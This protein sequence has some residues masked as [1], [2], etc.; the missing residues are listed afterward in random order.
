MVFFSHGCFSCLN[1]K[2]HKWPLGLPV[3]AEHWVQGMAPWTAVCRLTG[4]KGSVLKAQGVIHVPS[5]S[6]A[7]LSDT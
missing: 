5:H 2:R 7:D 3:T 1:P 4:G 6:T